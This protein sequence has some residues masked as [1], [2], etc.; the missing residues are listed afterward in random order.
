MN[1]LILLHDSH[2]LYSFASARHRDVTCIPHLHHSME[3]ILVTEG[4]LNMTVGDRKYT[5]PEGSGVFVPPFEVHDFSSPTSNRCH[6]LM[7]TRD[8]APHFFAFLQTNAPGNHLFHPSEEAFALSQRHLP[9][10]ENHVDYFTAMAVLSPLFS[11]ILSQCAFVPGNNRQDASFHKT[12]AYMNEHFTENISLATTAK[13]VGIH[14]VTLSRL[15]SHKFKS[16]FCAYL[17]YL[18]CSHAALLLTGSG[19]SC[20][21]IAYQSGFGSIRSFNRAFQSIYAISPSEYRKSHPG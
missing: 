1:P 21:E 14:P 17:N 3:V 7:F 19:A 11:D 9:E 10:E 5:I 8:L 4:T 18:R 16:N 6:V 13:A 20:T 12:I 2:I 15:F